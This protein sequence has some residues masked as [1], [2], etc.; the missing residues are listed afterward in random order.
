MPKNKKS[1]AQGVALKSLDEDSEQDKKTM[2]MLNA[3]AR[4][5]TLESIKKIEDFIAKTKNWHVLSYAELAL[6]E[7]T[8][9][10]YSPKNKQE[11]KEFFLAKMIYDEE[12]RA[13]RLMN[14]ADEAKLVLEKVK[15]ER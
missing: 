8:R 14:E 2:A 7:A 10:Y 15:I 1:M 9:I 4:E 13:Q 11:E 6:S 3:W 5:G 12:K